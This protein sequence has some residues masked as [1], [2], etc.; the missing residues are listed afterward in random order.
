MP[1]RRSRTCTVRKFA[2]GHEAAD[3]W[4]L[5]ISPAGC[6]TQKI[7]D[8]WVELALRH[9]L[10]PPPKSTARTRAKVKTMT[11]ITA[12]SQSPLSSVT[13]IESRSC[14]AWS[15]E[16]TGVLPRFTTYLGPRTAPAGFESSMPPV[17]IYSNSWRMAAKCCLTQ[18]PGHARRRAAQCRRP[19]CLVC[20]PPRASLVPRT[21]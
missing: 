17:T 9:A 15:A 5:A 21:S 1:E 10:S 16:S 20:W 4:D 13:S 19:R 2:R 6:A 18:G 3:A 8:R 12:R 11:P 7:V 14:R